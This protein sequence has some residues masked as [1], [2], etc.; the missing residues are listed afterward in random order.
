MR[1]TAKGIPG[2]RISFPKKGGREEFAAFHERLAQI[3]ESRPDIDWASAPVS[4]LK[5]VRFNHPAFT[6]NLITLM[7]KTFGIKHSPGSRFRTEED[8]RAFL[9]YALEDRM[10]EADNRRLEWHSASL[11]Q[12]DSIYIR[13]SVP[14]ETLRVKETSDAINR[15]LESERISGIMARV[16]RKRF[17]GDGKTLEEIGLEENISL[18]RV[19]QYEE[20][21][22]QKLRHPVSSSELREHALPDVTAPFNPD[23]A[24]RYAFEHEARF[25]VRLE[26]PTKRLDGMAWPAL[27]LGR[28]DKKALEKKMGAVFSQIYN[29]DST[30]QIREILQ[31]GGLGHITPGSRDGAILAIIK[32]FQ[33]KSGLLVRFRKYRVESFRQIS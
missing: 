25:R 16:I 18:E 9:W 12:S 17:W 31:E 20:R 15:E 13:L 10:I 3:L 22:L 23:H 8:F 33:E 27:S 6:G 29:A 11:G 24:H 19:R 26:A 1:G 32:D 7:H 14:G 28:N 4:V 2:A 5:K 30:S 21:A